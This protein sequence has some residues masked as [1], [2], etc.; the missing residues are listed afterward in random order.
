MLAQQLVGGLAIGCIYS[1]IALGY[2]MIIRAI[3]LVNFAQGEVMMVGALLGWTLVTTYML[4]YPLVLLLAMALT[5][6]LGVVIDWLAYRPLRQRGSPTMNLIITTIGVSIV[7]RNTAQLIWGSE[8]VRY[9]PVFGTEPLVI[10]GVSLAPHN[11]SI[12]LA[13]L[14]FMT[15]LHLFFQ[16]TRTGLA[17]RAAAQDPDMA[18]LMGI[19]VDRMVAYTFAMSA[20][21]GAA[22]G[23]LLAPI[24]FA[25]FDMGYIGIK[26]FAAATIGGLG[27]VPGAMVGGVALGMIET[28]GA[29]F[30]SSAYKDAIGY[31]IMILLLLFA[32]SGLFVRGHRR[33]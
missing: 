6:L 14:A 20:A 24:F 1:L 33:A 25:S 10:G 12:L 5:A 2:T 32:P 27:N 21:L 19:S 4:P 28:L 7:L 8:P 18:R 9:P 22:G 13:G 23:V 15:A 17:M 30:V 29:A 3:G 31:G 26:S 16:K 11:V